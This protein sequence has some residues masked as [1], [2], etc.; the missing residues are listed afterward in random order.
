MAAATASS[1]TASKIKMSITSPNGT[2]SYVGAIWNARAA[3]KIRKQISNSAV[4]Q[5]A[6]TVSS[7]TYVLSTATVLATGT[8]NYIATGR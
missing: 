6:F 2:V 8:C 4:A 7:Y 3:C 5:N 1:F